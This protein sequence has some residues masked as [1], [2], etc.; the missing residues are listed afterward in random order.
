MIRVSAVVL[1]FNEER[2][3]ERCLASVKPVADEIVVVDSF[4]TDRTPEICRRY[5]SRFIQ[6]AFEGYLEQA[7]WAEGQAQNDHILS[8]DAD[9]AL[10]PELAASILTAKEEWR[11][12]GYRMNRRNFYAGR[13]L[14]H[15]GWYPDRKLRLY[16]RRRG[17]Q[18]GMNPHYDVRMDAQADVGFLK[19][20]LLHY[21]YYSVKEHLAQADRFASIAAR[22][23]AG[24]G[25][26]RNVI[27][28]LTHPWFRFLK[29]YVLKAGAL[30]GW[31]G[32]AA[33]GVA[34]WE[35]FLK[36]ARATG[37]RP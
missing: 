29:G 25:R 28:A 20:D 18:E 11:F 14:R 5:A 30:D 33:A 37:G 10:S 24:R 8:I 21:T 6:H 17:R 23:L 2:D 3:I 34:S 1:S 15:G 36:Y 27:S 13:F 22:R 4:S 9:E 32:V 19:G 16:D 26:V 35:V 12:D 31:R 7:R